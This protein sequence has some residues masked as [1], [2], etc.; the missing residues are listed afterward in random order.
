MTAQSK[1]IFDEALGLPSEEKALLAEQLLASLDV[2]S[3]KSI[4]EKWAQEAEKRIDAYDRGEIKAI[5][6]NEVF[7]KIYKR[8]KL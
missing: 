7:E 6:A 1:R 5:P 3:S 2:S 8:Q 4:D